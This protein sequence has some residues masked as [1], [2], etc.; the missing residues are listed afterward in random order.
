MKRVVLFFGLLV[1]SGCGLKAN[2]L[3]VDPPPRQESPTIELSFDSL[4]ITRRALEADREAS[5]VYRVATPLTI[6][7]PAAQRSRAKVRI[8]LVNRLP[9][10][11]ENTALSE[12]RL[13]GENGVQLLQAED[14]VVAPN[15]IRFE[16]NAQWQ[17]GR[18]LEVA[19]IQKD[20]S[21][22]RVKAPLRELPK[23]LTFTERPFS[24]STRE[25]EVEV[26]NRIE[27][28]YGLRVLEFVNPTEWPLELDLNT[29]LSDSRVFQELITWT[30][31]NISCKD[32]GVKNQASIQHHLM[33]TDVW[34]RALR[35]T[36]GYTR[37]TRR[38]QQSFEP[39]ESRITL[40]P[41]ESVRIGLYASG[42]EMQ[43][44]KRSGSLKGGSFVHEPLVGIPCA[45]GGYY[46]ADRK[47]GLQYGSV[48]LE[49]AARHLEI[50]LRY[51]D[52]SYA[53]E[54]GRGTASWI[55]ALS[56]VPDHPSY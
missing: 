8:R 12:I 33:S 51:A 47:T 25:L 45:G 37:P 53:N 35:E 9:G 44:F 3:A 7:T 28:Y 30:P 22:I 54:S 10:I 50:S 23:T 26:G 18:Q 55:S 11:D 14:V 41:R 5:G 31:Q 36:T 24:D 16:T 29:E 39:S 13:I 6:H 1:S 48:Y 19:F 49:L 21:V 38:R 20:Q 2:P 15:Q 32:G 34:M 52:Q 4:G 46:H 27:T 42:P 40:A 56:V 43:R 17:G